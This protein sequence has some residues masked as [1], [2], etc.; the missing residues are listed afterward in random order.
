MENLSS[1][2]RASRVGI[3][4][5]GRNEGERLRRCL[6]SIGTLAPFAVYVDSGS[7][8]GSV[9]LARSRGVTVVELDPRIPFT[10]AR[11]R[12]E[13]FERLSATAPGIE[14][15]QF[16]DGDCELAA[17][18][19]A[20][21]EEFLRAHAEVAMVCG[22]LRERNPD[23]SV[24]NMLCELEWD[25]PAGPT[26]ACG[27][28]AVVRAAAF[29]A[30]GGFRAELIAGE[31][32]DLCARLRYAGWR[33]HRLAAEM[34]SHDA[35][36]TRFGQ[37]WTRTVRGGF[38]FAQAAH[39]HGAGPDRLGIRESLSIWAWAFALPVAVLGGALAWGSGALALLLA[40]PLQVVRLALRGE[41]PGAENWWQ[42]VFFMLGKFAQLL[43]QWRYL[44]LRVGGQRRARL[45]EYK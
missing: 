1:S 10:A 34:A 26:L 5:I 42:A 16:L 43:G 18:W 17:G 21:A 7:S 35:A 38:A 20:V 45:I 28:I 4:V 11:A 30:V 15:V 39:L 31:E 36:I 37:W 14:F 19:L 6:D 2:G 27:G 13:G 9:A 3:V 40:Y 44:A 33:V 41:H 12:N 23:A 8:D 24:Y 32:G 22:R 29:A 25:R